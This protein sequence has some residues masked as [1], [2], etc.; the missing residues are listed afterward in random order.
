MVPVGEGTFRLSKGA[1][2]KA[3]MFSRSA[4]T[5]GE[6]ADA[7]QQLRGL[8]QLGWSGIAP[9]SEGKGLRNRHYQWFSAD[10]AFNRI[11]IRARPPPGRVAES[12]L[13]SSNVC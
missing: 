5:R 4:C 11:R 2:G 10:S 6:S 9:L 13:P 7:W 1:A 12:S 8:L 3:H